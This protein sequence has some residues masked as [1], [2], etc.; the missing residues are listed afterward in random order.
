[1]DGHIPNR[2]KLI[3]E[4]IRE[5]FPNKHREA[6]ANGHHVQSSPL[7]PDEEV[8]RV[9]RDAKNSQKFEDLFDKGDVHQH[10][11]GDDSG[12]DQG[13]VNM[14]AFVTQ[15]PEQ[16]DRF[17]RR[18]AL[19]R[20]KWDEVHRGDG[21]TY[22]DMTI[23]KATDPEY[24]KATYQQHDGTSIH[25]GNRDGGAGE[26][27]AISQPKGLQGRIKLGERITKGVEE[28]EQIVKGIIYRARTHA[29]NS[30]PGEGKTLFAL[31]VCLQRLS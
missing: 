20:P 3:N 12:A 4:L 31:W 1:M 17:F 15:D 13:L 24:L 16:I 2:Q 19:M 26:Q 10:H 29:V 27:S 5:H 11:D 8:E 23:E 7:L 28:P 6:S 18:S 21:A 25:L 9:L 22:G 30:D 14:I